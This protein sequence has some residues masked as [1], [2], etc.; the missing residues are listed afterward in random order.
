[1]I[2][3]VRVDLRAPA[4]GACLSD[5]ERAR[6]ARFVVEEVRVRWVA[7]RAAL[8]RVLAEWLEVSAADVRFVYGPAGKPAVADGAVCFN[9][10]HSRDVALIAVGDVELG[11]DVEVMRN[12]PE[13][14]GIADRL[15]GGRPA[16]VKEFLRLWT[17][18]EALIKGLGIGVAD[19]IDGARAAGWHVSDLD[20][21]GDVVGALAVLG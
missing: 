17:R 14:E 7:C 1:M 12:V 18:R 5:D 16:G 6:A 19:A 3:V 11:V 8:R 10:S 15:L 4:D 2:D 9:V 21:G 20:V 13:W